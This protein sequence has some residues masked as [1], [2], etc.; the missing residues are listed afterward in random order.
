[1]VEHIFE[2]IDDLKA[3]G[4]TILLVE[5]NVHHALDSADRAYV[6]ESGRITLEGTAADLRHDPRVESRYLG[7]AERWATTSC[8]RSSTRSARAACTR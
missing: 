7:S 1:M 6:M 3:Q 2:L 8:S 4:L 5:Q